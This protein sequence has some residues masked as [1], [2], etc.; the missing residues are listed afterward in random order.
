M[1]TLKILLVITF[2]IISGFSKD[3]Q[4]DENMFPKNGTDNSVTVP[5]KVWGSTIDNG[6]DVTPCDCW[7]GLSHTRYGFLQGHQ[8]HGGELN[9]Y[10]STWEIKECWTSGWKNTSRIEGTN[11][12][13]NGDTYN[14]TAIMIFPDF[15]DPNFTMDIDLEGG[16]GRFA[17]ATGHVKCTGIHLLHTINFTGEGYI[18]FLK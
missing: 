17:G 18:T 1:K 4:T 16:T 7:Y 10:A 6:T 15:R 8:T 14:Y 3:S 11:T 13:A 2:V 12:V 5:M 9:T